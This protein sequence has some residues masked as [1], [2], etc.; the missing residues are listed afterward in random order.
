MKIYTKTGDDGT[1]SLANGQRVS[2]TDPRL[3]AYGTADELNSFVGLLRAKTENED[4]TPVLHFIQNKLFNLGAQLAGCNDLPI[5]ADDVTRIEQTI[6]KMS[7]NLPVYHG[8]L[9]PA[10]SEVVALCHICRTV[11]RRLERNILAL[12][13]TSVDPN[14][15]IFVNRLSDFFFVLA[16][17]NM[18]KD[19]NKVFLWEK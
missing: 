15:V 5:I 2:K 4:F 19:E 8:F 13:K 6:D 1:T 7:E 14:S 9:L 10:G 18:I 16:K 12:E 3:E 11:T 17:K